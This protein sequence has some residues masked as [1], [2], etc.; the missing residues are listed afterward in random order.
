MKNKDERQKNATTASAHR[1]IPADEKERTS[2]VVNLYTNGLDEPKYNLLHKAQQSVAANAPGFLEA[3][4]NITIPAEMM[5]L[6]HNCLA[7]PKVFHLFWMDNVYSVQRKRY[8]SNQ[9]ECISTMSQTRLQS[10][11]CG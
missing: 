7:K 4:N 3:L 6:Y 10:E 1:L 8:N 5:F 11:N 2:S 9:W